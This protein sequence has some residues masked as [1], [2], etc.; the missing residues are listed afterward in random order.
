VTGARVPRHRRLAIFAA[1]ALMIGAPGIAFWA[2]PATGASG[3]PPGSELAGINTNAISAAARVVTFTPGIAPLGDA[4]QGN[5]VEA[6]LPYSN[7]TAG[8]GP[9]TGGTAALVWPGSVISTL[10]GA[11]ATF[12]P[13]TPQALVD[14][15][16]YPIAAHSS[17]PEQLHTK[18]T[19]TF[20]PGGIGTSTTTSHAGES[21]ARAVLTDLS[22]L[23]SKKIP[24][25]NV[26]SI[27]TSTSVTVN[28]SSVT[29]EAHTHVGH[30]TI[31]GVIDIAGIDST[32]IASSDGVDGHHSSELHIGKVTVAGVSAS[33]GPKGLTLNQTTPKLPL[34]LLDVANTALTALQQAGISLKLLP[35]EG[36][37]ED[38]KGSA[39]SGSVQ[40]LFKDSNIPNLGAVL[41]QVPL[42]LPHSLGLEVELGGSIAS[43]AATQLPDTTT[44]PPPPT[45]TE[46][47]GTTPGGT[48]LGGGA[49]PVDFPPGPGVVSS[50]PG[51]PGPIVAQP[52]AS[53]LGVPI[54]AAWVVLAF[55]LSL[56]AAGPLLA[57]AN[58]QLLRGRTQ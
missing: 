7:S 22:L 11:A 18:S 17:Y 28:A 32:A 46:P 8:T 37:N 3:G 38:N 5:I 26:A 13:T 2:T 14:L 25:I 31:A 29:T 21:N 33:I 43:A 41:P 24:L 44:V 42:P 27:T 30:I 57:Y 12:A 53:V 49:G 54:R 1:T 34:D 6:S 52:A 36:V 51:G 48:D 35:A 19:G 56:V 15:L 50:P 47:P 39:T 58:W 20:S 40:F 9:T 4:V 10:G 16:N 55:L 23:G 45:S